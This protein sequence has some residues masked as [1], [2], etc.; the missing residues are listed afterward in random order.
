MSR[1]LNENFQVEL[2][3]FTQKR[4]PLT[5]APKIQKTVSSNATFNQFGRALYKLRKSFINR[6]DEK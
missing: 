2:I 4:L 1:Q 6:P 5:H 3:D